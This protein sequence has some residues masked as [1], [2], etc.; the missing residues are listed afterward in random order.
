MRIVEPEEAAQADTSRTVRARG[1]WPS[2]LATGSKKAP[3]PLASWVGRLL[4]RLCLDPLLTRRARVPH[5]AA[6]Q[7]TH[8][9][10]T[11]RLCSVH[12]DVASQASD[13]QPGCGGHGR[14]PPARHFHRHLRVSIQP[15]RA[16]APPRLSA[17]ARP[18]GRLAACL[19][20]PHLVMPRALRSPTHT[21][22]VASSRVL[23]PALCMCWRA[24][25]GTAG[26]ARVCAPHVPPRV[27]RLHVA[28][29]ASQERCSWWLAS[30]WEC[31][32]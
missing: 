20:L 7:R 16:P 14:D 17:L 11:M 19:G 2:D 6:P 3:T 12:A 24:R 5:E 30:R 29:R 4:D 15:G 32:S 8:T 21:P 9:R 25:V 22:S 27:S 28:C 18:A 10:H 31:P 13:H 26:V 1:G 23:M